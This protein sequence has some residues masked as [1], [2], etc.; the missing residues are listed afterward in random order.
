ME[1]THPSD[2]LLLAYL[3]VSL[4]K[5]EDA[6]VESHLRQCDTC[7]RSLEL[8]QGRAG[9]ADEIAVGVPAAV[10]ARV[11]FAPREHSR[12]RHAARPPRWL[13]RWPVLVPTSLAAGFLLGAV[14][15]LV[16]SPAT[17]SR[18]TRGVELGGS[19]SVVVSDTALRREPD[20][21]ADVVA[22]LGRG[23]HVKVIQRR[24]D[25]VRIEGAAGGQGWVR[26]EQLR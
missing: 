6:L 1:S 20:D 16:R 2:E 25:W 7:V 23:E 19:A 4:Q 15:S 5:A 17:P 9:S 26:S 13:L 12:P 24:A 21:A 3:D 11:A 22:G 14:T 8:M 10:A 18:M